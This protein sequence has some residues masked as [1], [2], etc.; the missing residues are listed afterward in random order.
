[1]VV[2]QHQDLRHQITAQ[3]L[4]NLL[5]AIMGLLEQLQVTIQDAQKESKSPHQHH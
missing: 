2:C 1:L 5:L 3:V 4:L